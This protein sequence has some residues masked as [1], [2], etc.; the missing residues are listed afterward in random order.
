MKPFTTFLWSTSIALSW[1]WGLGLFFS[2]QISVMFGVTGLLCFAIPNGIGLAL[3]GLFTDQIARRAGS[4]ERLAED[5]IAR[6]KG[7]RAIFLFYQ[8]MAVALSVFALLKYGILP[9]Q[10]YLVVIAILFLGLALF[11]GDEF[12]IRG[13]K[14]IHG[15]YF[16]GIV[17]CL[18][19]IFIFRVY[20]RS[21]IFSSENFGLGEDP[22]WTLYFWS[23]FIPMIVGFLVGPWLDLQQ[24]QRA[25]QIAREKGSIRNAY[26]V[27]SVLFFG[28]ILVHGLL[29][30]WVLG[31]GGDSF[32]SI[33][34]SWFGDQA[35]AGHEIITRYFQ[36]T[37]G[38]PNTVALWCYLGFVALAIISTLD[39]AY[40][41]TKWYL[42]EN[43][44]NSQSVLL[45][46]LPKSLCVSPIPLAM[47]AGVI[48][49]VG[50]IPV[51]RIELEYFMVFYATFFVGY[52]ILLLAT[53]RHRFVMPR[54]P[55][56]VF[57]VALVS[58]A[59]FCLGYFSREYCWLMILGSLI[60]VAQA[61]WLF[62]RPN[63]PA[64]SDVKERLTEF[65]ENVSKEVAQMATT[66]IA[67]VTNVPAIQPAGEN[68]GSSTYFEGKW[69]VYT[70]TTT[71]CDTN[72]VGN[73]YFANYAKWVGSTRELFFQ[74]A[75]PFFDLKTTPFFILTREF[76]HKF[77][78]ETKEFQKVFVK[79]RVGSYN[80]KFVT[81]EHVVVDA[82]GLTIGKGE[83]SLMFV[84]SADYKL[85]DLPAE[86]LSAFMK[87]I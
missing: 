9:V 34:P 56:Q 65:R 36:S 2:V 7:F 30:L 51:L 48:G 67:N 57:A 24:W 21:E 75:M 29:A 47:L 68:Q 66:A 37:S 16:L 81:L 73:V 69:F 42:Q 6:A 79:I 58:L 71:Y 46:F 17:L 23:Y 40:L 43:I 35:L 77:I 70:F 41:A 87:Y 10:G 27:G 38:G 80:R 4:A 54:S 61:V 11:I 60:P 12:D 74:H 26:L 72:S 76:N 63:I 83:Q 85:V 25:I 50:A 31:Q 86:V 32:L 78:R 53:I 82:G 20:P 5:F 44:K 13:I 1:L 3:F 52:E 8:V 39:S 59:V 22:P 28:L 49:V 18:G 15:W 14:F 19:A 84:S 62:T 55:L 64:M 45:S 33:A